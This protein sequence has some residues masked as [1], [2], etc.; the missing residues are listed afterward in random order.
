[1]CS[2]CEGCGLKNHGLPRSDRIRNY[3]VDL[4]GVFNISSRR[5]HGGLVLIGRA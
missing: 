3:M 2:D 1:M 5:L 4:C